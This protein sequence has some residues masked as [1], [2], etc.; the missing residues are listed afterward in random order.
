MPQFR[1]LCLIRATG[2]QSIQFVEAA[3][4]ESATQQLL[5]AGFIV[6]RVEA[7]ADAPP[8]PPLPPP[9]PA[10]AARSLPATPPPTT[11]PSWLWQFFTFRIMVLP[12][13]VRTGFALATLFAILMTI[14]ALVN[15]F[16]SGSNAMGM[17]AYFALMLQLAGIWGGW[18]I[19][20]LMGEL[21]IVIFS[22]N[23]HAAAIAR[24][25]VNAPRPTVCRTCGY[26]LR[27]LEVG[28]P[29]PECG[30]R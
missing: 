17:P 3:D 22:I 2:K 30:T 19:W 11:Q 12:S 9:P 7:A 8:P 25:S 13:L 16:N 20:R 15:Y 23:E 14:T 18:F 4:A 27:G 28:A 5:A 24:D 26:N 6:G 1:A 10:P 21:L 29:C